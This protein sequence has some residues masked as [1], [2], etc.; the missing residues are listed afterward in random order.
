MKQQEPILKVYWGLGML[1]NFSQITKLPRI[2]RP[3]KQQNIMVRHT[4]FV[5]RWI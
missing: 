5:V 2:L 4:D 3:W 1:D